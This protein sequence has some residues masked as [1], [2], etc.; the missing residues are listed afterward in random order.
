MLLFLIELY[1]FSLKSL[2]TLIITSNCDQCLADRK[3][4]QNEFRTKRNH[5]ENWF[6]SAVLCNFSFRETIC[7]S[8][9]TMQ[10]I[11]CSA[12]RFYATESV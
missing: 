6:S 2:R 3:T 9:V 1:L 5:N 12:L 8:S 4:K 7:C 10:P 11:E